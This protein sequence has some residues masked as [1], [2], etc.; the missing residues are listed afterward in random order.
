V[1]SPAMIEDAKLWS[2]RR[3]A[4]MECV[5]ALANPHQGRGVAGHPGLER[6][7]AAGMVGMTLGLTRGL[8]ALLEK[9]HCWIRTY[10][11]GAT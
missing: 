4:V 1:P 8:A 10:G 9:L 2:G 3:D 11:S 6:V 7:Y 5:P